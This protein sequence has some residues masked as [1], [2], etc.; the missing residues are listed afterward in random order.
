M[1]QQLHSRGNPSQSL[2]WGLKRAY[3]LLDLWKGLKRHKE[4]LQVCNK[5]KEKIV[6]E[7][8]LPRLSQ[9]P[10]LW[11]TVPAD[12]FFIESFALRGA[13]AWLLFCSFRNFSS[14]HASSCSRENGERLSSGGQRGRLNARQNHHQHL[15]V[16]Q[17]IEEEICLVE[18][19]N[20]ESNSSGCKLQR[21]YRVTQQV[22]PG[23]TC[24]DPK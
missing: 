4:S 21:K 3:L 23:Q 8:Y 15:A 20:H 19:N 16:R 18:L 14:R 1:S 5:T 11:Y 9:Q 24:L 17:D 10:L 6:T 13:D 2:I 12:A 7:S 22:K